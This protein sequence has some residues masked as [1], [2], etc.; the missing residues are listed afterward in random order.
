MTLV[1]SLLFFYDLSW[2]KKIVSSVTCETAGRNYDF[3]FAD[4]FNN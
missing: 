3:I 2:F 4:H 1:D